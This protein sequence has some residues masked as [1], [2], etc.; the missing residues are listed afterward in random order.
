MLKLVVW[1]VQRGNAAYLRTPNGKHIVVDLGTGSYKGRDS[2]FS[3]LLHLRDMWD[4][5][6]LDCV[7]ITHPHLDHIDDVLNYYLLKPSFLSRPRHLTVDEIWAN[8]IVED[9]DKKLKIEE[10]LEINKIFSGE[11]LDPD[12]TKPANNGG[13]DIQIF[14]PTT[15]A[16]NNLNNHSVTITISYQGCKVLMPGDNEPLCWEEL[17]SQPAFREAIAGTDILVAPH[18]GRELGYHSELFKYFKPRLTVIS[19]GRFDDKSA[20]ERYGKVSSGW[21]VHK[22]FGIDEQR[23]CLNTR[24]D[25]VI[26][27]DMGTNSEKRPFISVNAGM[28]PLAIALL[29]H[30]LY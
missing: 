26:V 21:T 5:S 13:V 19:A 14:K 11:P 29:S 18:H 20:M 17:L 28:P 16:R 2:T 30:L 12:P 4:V 9:N 7:I 22:G 24:D 1:D 15:C 3:P 8:N 25:G 23:K 6:K 27:I 10:Y